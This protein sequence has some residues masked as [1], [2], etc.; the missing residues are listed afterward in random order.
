MLNLNKNRNQSPVSN[1]KS[2]PY[3]KNLSKTQ[4]KSSFD[5]INA[6]ILVKNKIDFPKENFERTKG[7]TL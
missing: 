3:F 7:G 5:I 6:N 4:Y 2:S 1:H